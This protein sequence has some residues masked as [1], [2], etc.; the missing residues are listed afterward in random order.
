MGDRD[1]ISEGQLEVAVVVT[2]PGRNVLVHRP[3]RSSAVRPSPWSTLRARTEGDSLQAAVR[4]I[5]VPWL[6]DRVSG[7]MLNYLGRV[8]GLTGQFSAVDVYEVGWTGAGT[9][10]LKR[11]GMLYEADFVNLDELAGLPL[12]QA[13]AAAF[14]TYAKSLEKPSTPRL[15]LLL[16]SPVTST[17]ESTVEDIFAVEENSYFLRDL[18]NLLYVEG[19][20]ERCTLR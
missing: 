3:V 9:A 2:A 10:T 18:L 7:S 14:A 19:T 20:G 15:T 12:T 17:V 4:L 8:R 13:G 1:L 6:R 11:D 5:D 16:R